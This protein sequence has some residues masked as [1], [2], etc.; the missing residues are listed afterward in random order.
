[1][2]FVLMASPAFAHENPGVSQG[3]LSGFTHPLTGIDHLLAMVAVGIW[4]TQ[5][6]QPAIWLLPV[7]FPLVMSLGGVLGVRGV[8]IP[9]VEIGVAGSA[10][11]L[12][13]MIVLRA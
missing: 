5:L 1:V 9:A 8:P 3:F 13:I 11:V 6:G 7:T 10:V 12:G 2:L 4:G